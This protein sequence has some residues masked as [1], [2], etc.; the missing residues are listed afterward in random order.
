MRKKETRLEKLGKELVKTRDEYGLD[1]RQMDEY[2]VG[3]IEAREKEYNRQVLHK[4]GKE[5]SSKAIKW[6][7][8]LTPIE[9][10]RTGA[11]NKEQI[12]QAH[13]LAYPGDSKE[14]EK[15][16]GTDGRRP[17][18]RDHT[19]DSLGPP[20]HDSE[21]NIRPGNRSVMKKEPPHIPSAQEMGK[22]SVKEIADT[23][24]KIREYRWPSSNEDESVPAGEGIDLSEMMKG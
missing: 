2:V 1:D 7:R 24:R 4:Y 9:R 16:V 8:D 14:I 12:I 6:W 17:P 20:E 19:Y 3:T 22:M 18:V 21:G 23:I 10:V 11:E 13:I 5:R 15:V